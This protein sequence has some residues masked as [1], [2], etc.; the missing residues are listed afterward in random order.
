MIL[1]WSRVNNVAKKKKMAHF[2][3]CNWIEP[4]VSKGTTGESITAT[5]VQEAK[6]GNLTDFKLATLCLHL[7]Y[8]V[9][10]T[11]SNCA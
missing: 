5:V 7:C 10:K 6:P 3:T 1:T 4:K 9:W 2:I 11:N 8:M